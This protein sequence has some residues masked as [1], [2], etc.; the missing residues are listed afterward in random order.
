[1]GHVR[2]SEWWPRAIALASAVAL[3]P[4][5]QPDGVSAQ[6]AD[7]V[8]VVAGEAVVRVAPDV[9][10]FDVTAEVRRRSPRDAQR[11]A[12][13]LM[14]AVQARLEQAGLAESALE[15][16]GYWVAPEFEFVD[17]RRVL[18]GYVA[19]NTIEV[20]VDDLARAGELVD[21]A[22]S[23]GATAVGDLRFERRDRQAVAR[24]ALQAAVADALARAQAAAAGAGR[25]VDRVVRIEESGVAP[26]PPVPVLAA[27]GTAAEA[28][29]TPISPG[30]I[31]VRV[32]VTLTAAIR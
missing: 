19:R 11:E 17:G 18:R 1:M 27:R 13:E 31:E 22:V 7:S 2:T 10:T 26:P 29:P 5:L 15:T 20:R 28:A 4:L 30:T 14:A 24:Q 8:V 25:A 23:A 12:A 16:R 21:V 32:R 6:P 9:A 3:A